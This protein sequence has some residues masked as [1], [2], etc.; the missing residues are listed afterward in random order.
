[1]TLSTEVSWQLD[2]ITMYG[3]VTHPDGEGPFPG[4]VL[5]AGSG[6]TD[7]DWN[8]P[9]MPGTNGSGRLLAEA[10][11]DAGYASIRYDKRASGP[12]VMQNLPALAGHISMQAHLDELTAAVERFAAQ[13]SVD[14]SR[15]AGFGNSEGCLHLLHYAS[16]VHEDPGRQHP[17]SALVLTGAPGRSVGEVFVSQLTQQL[18]GAPDL[19]PL[20]AEAAA[21]YSAG[22]PAD[23]DERLPEPV[24]QAFQSF[25]TP[26]NLP[27]AREL[28]NEDAADSLAL[29]TIPT[30]VVIGGKDVQIDVRA[31]GDP[32]QAAA[33]GRAGVSFVFPADADHVLKHEPRSREEVLAS[34]VSSYNAD[35]ARL[36]AEAM[37]VILDWLRTELD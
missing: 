2:G 28:W 21:R 27:F 32:L 35:D 6:P 15:L 30:L 7:R 12:H 16:P 37:H 25:E 24:R 17:L 34:G 4:V 9:L 22:E 20:V 1:M 14:A 11:A 13:P 10:L 29:V 18:A 8:S 31:D 5:V 23:P 33:Q 26:M 19:L 36:D 3:T